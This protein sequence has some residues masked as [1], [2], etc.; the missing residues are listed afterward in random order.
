MTNAYHAIKEHQM[1]VW[2][3]ARVYCVPE[4]TL[5]QRALG[6]VDPEKLTSGVSP[7]LSL[8]EEAAFVDHLKVMA[9]CGYGYTRSEVVNMA[10]EYACSLQK[11][12]RNHPFS[13]KWFKGFMM[14]WP[15]LNVSKPRALS[16]ARAKS[17]S[18]EVVSN[19]YRE[20]DTILKK[21]DLVD[22]PQC[23]YNIDE[24]GLQTE[25]RP[26]CIV[27][28]KMS[29]TPA[30]TSARSSTVTVIGCGN[31]L[32]TQ[33]PPYFVFQGARMRQE[34]MEGASEGAQ[35]TVTDSGWSNSEVFQTYLSEH[36]LKYV[37]R[38][39]ENQPILILY[40][41]HRSH[42]NLT[43]VD[44]AKQHNIVLFVLP[45]HT[46]HVLQ[47]LDLGCFGPFQE[48]YNA[49]C[50]KFLRENP[51]SK[52]TR[53]NIC[54]LACKAYAHALSQG[55]LQSSF[56]RAGIFPF[57]KN[58]VDPSNFAPS[59]VFSAA[60]Q[61]PDQD[62]SSS[63]Q[64]IPS[65]SDPKS[66][67]KLHT[68][69]I[70]NKTKSVLTEKRNIS[71]VVSGKPITEDSVLQEIKNYSTTK[72]TSKRKE[73][74]TSTCKDL[75]R[76]K[77]KHGVSEQPESS[78]ADDTEDEK[79]KCC[80]CKHFWP[81]EIKDCDLVVFVKWAQCS[82]EKCDHWT[83]LQFCCATKVIRRGDEFICPCHNN[84]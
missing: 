61:Y 10:S 78:D 4:T 49:E 1:S 13:M 54:S 32:G 65:T 37:Q 39:N 16:A 64:A 48:I 21:Y 2:K 25:H 24:K 15:E 33:M 18:E 3:A 8:E 83:H 55:N 56:R 58:A 53:Y 75:C 50:H 35:G 17:T 51:S 67:F 76:K 71:K 77:R 81:E 7:V 47:P 82:F 72:Q 29:T 69:P 30:I 27:G 73:K 23:I 74:T 19:Y 36:F 11:R 57:D 26:P 12:D 46:S 20:L 59:I 28:S 52:I 44:W 42:I 80:V 60:E 79:E 40:D 84:K 22:K 38:P 9:S 14:R 62:A 68:N 63:T 41:G 5:R 70:F 45:A 43:L 6:R 31:A 34:L 66:F